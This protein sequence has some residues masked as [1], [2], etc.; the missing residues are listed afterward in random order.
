MPSQTILGSTS[1]PARH[2]FRAQT[3]FE[4]A[5][6]GNHAVRI[7]SE[8]RCGDEGRRRRGPCEWSRFLVSSSP[9]FWAASGTPAS[10]EQSGR[11]GWIG[12]CG[13]RCSRERRPHGE[14][15]EMLTAPSPWSARY[16][17]VREVMACR[18][19]VGSTMSNPARPSVEGFHRVRTRSRMRTR[20]LPSSAMVICVYLCDLWGG[21]PCDAPIQHPAPSIDRLSP[22]SA[23]CGSPR[24]RPR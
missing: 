20:T 15:R 4:G 17:I 10:R 9:A 11:W 2:A 7:S 21:G 14:R 19:A 5:L 6:A 1:Q 8:R 3:S 13:P 24:E 12:R 18:M 22:D 16:D 23:Q